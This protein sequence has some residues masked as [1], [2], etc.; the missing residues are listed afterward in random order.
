MMMTTTVMTL[1]I[2]SSARWTVSKGI[3]LNKLQQWLQQQQQHKR[4]VNDCSIS[5]MMAMTMT[6][7]SSILRL[8]SS[9]AR[10]CAL[11]YARHLI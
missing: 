2:N 6:T 4:T 7:M 11:Y 8:V 1:V 3:K 10:A 9:L 5:L